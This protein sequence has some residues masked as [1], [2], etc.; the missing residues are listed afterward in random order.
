MVETYSNIKRNLGENTGAV[1]FRFMRSKLSLSLFEKFT[2]LKSSAIWG[3][4]PWSNSHHSQRCA[5]MRL[6]PIIHLQKCPHEIPWYHMISTSWVILVGSKKNTSNPTRYPRKSNW[7]LPWKSFSIPYKLISHEP[8]GPTL[9]QLP[10]NTLG[11]PRHFDPDSHQRQGSQKGAQ[12]DFVLKY[13]AS[14]RDVTIF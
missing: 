2:D 14:R 11:H 10:P 3:W 7:N 9:K 6:R 12:R 13:F 5:T 4:F 1:F 8:T